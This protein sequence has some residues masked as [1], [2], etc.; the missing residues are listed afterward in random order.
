M[1]VGGQR[2]PVGRERTKIK[3]GNG[4]EQTSRPKIRRKERIET[5][6]RDNVPWGVLSWISE[7]DVAQGGIV[8]KKKECTTFSRKDRP[9]ISA[10]GTGGE[11]PRIRGG[12]PKSR[13]KEG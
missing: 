11:V 6:R 12:T 9:S 3:N 7:G 4:Q 1:L 13:R 10:S 5:Q 2:T 8:R